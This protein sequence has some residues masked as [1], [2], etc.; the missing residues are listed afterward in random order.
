MKMQRFIAG[1]IILCVM[2]AQ[3]AFAQEYGPR[4]G[5]GRPGPG[6]QGQSYQGSG[7]E[8]W[9]GGP[10]GQWDH[11]RGY[12]PERRYEEYRGPVR[13]AGPY[14]DLYRGG[15]LPPYYRS[16]VY[17]VNDW[18]LHRLYAPPRGYYWAQVGGDYVLAAIT[19]G[20]I[21]SVLLR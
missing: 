16:R 15:Y 19:T 3:S 17:I 2:A 18:R 14:H 8:G 1:A 9:R 12:G 11:G 7:P 6:Y 21:L 5:Y 4:G 20:V 10:R 13:G